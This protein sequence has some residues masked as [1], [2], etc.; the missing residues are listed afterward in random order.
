M[1]VVLPNQQSQL[2]WKTGEDM[3]CLIRIETGVEDGE[4]GFYEHG[5]M[6]D[7]GEECTQGVICR[8]VQ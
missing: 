7:C 6:R 8:N 4:N 5:G 3:E 2:V 1:E